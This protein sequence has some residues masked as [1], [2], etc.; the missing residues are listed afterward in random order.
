[1]RNFYIIFCLLSVCLFTACNSNK[2]RDNRIMVT[3]EPQRYFAEQLASP[4]FTVETMVPA[5]SNPETFDPTPNQMEALSRCKAYWAVGELGFEISWLRKI[6]ENNPDLRFFKTSKGVEP[7]VSVVP[8]GDHTHNVM[9]PHIWTSPK[10]VKVMVQ[11][12]Y[13]SLIALDPENKEVYTENLEKVNA[14]IDRVDENIREILSNSSQKAFII[15]HPALSYF[16]R[17]YGLTEISIEMNGKE[18]SPELLKNIIETARTENIQTVFIQQEFDQKNA[19]TIAKE[20]SAKLVVINPL[21]YN[22][23]EEIIGI[24]RALA[25][26]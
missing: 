7:I 17:D 3:I 10:E 23:S 21:S 2:Q 1:M 8:H 14:E 22:W 20:T 18:P 24:A 9:D 13:E 26:E 6:K 19:E 12:M 5:G 15:Y 4:F 11:N 25:N 16:A